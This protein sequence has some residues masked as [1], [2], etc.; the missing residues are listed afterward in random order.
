MFNSRVIIL[1]REATSKTCRSFGWRAG[2]RRCR[3]SA[4]NQR[5]RR[6][7]RLDTEALMG[8]A[9]FAVWSPEE[10]GFSHAHELRD[11]MTPIYSRFA[12]RMCGIKKCMQT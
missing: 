12:I 1:Q 10:S 7:G 5:V 11:G 4:R 8:I 3:G 6:A 9:R 2:H